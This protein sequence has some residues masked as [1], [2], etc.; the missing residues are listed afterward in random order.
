MIGKK[1]PK[2]IKNLFEIYYTDYTHPFTIFRRLTDTITHNNII[3][4]YQQFS[5]GFFKFFSFNNYSRLKYSINQFT[6]LNVRISVDFFYFVP[7]RNYFQL[8]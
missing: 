5:S 1:K 8:Q 7:K 4:K 2:N 3:Y 6:T